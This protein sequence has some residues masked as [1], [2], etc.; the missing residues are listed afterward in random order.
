MS[1][2]L[3]SGLI[4][5][6]TTLKIEQF[7]LEYNPVNYPF[8]GI[9]TTVSGVGFNLAKALT[10]LGNRVNFL[11]IIGDDFAGDLVVNTAQQNRIGTEFILKGLKTTAQSVIIFDQNGKRQIHTDLK[12]IQEQTYPLENFI[13][14]AQP[15]EG[16]AMCNINFSRALLEKAVSMN[17]LV[18]TDV[19][20]LSNL[21]DT[22]NKDFM[23]AANVIFMSDESLPMPPE[24]WATAI[25]DRYHPEVLVI[26]LGSKGALLCVPAES[27]LDFYPAVQTRPI[28]NTIGAG[29]ALFSSFLHSY[30]KSGNPYQSL[31]KAILFASYKIGVKS[32]ADGFL[33][34]QEL[35]ELHQQMSGK[36]NA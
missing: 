29:D 12:D 36:S 25:C 10:V 5:I 26:G 35:Q 7:P 20:T 1:H 17:K 28:V 15:C 27:T 11:S 24:E 21:D 19:H 13:Q 6:E 9:N 14:A 33:S 32:A 8:F 3:V 34:D 18:A 23:N 31:E 30:L 22:Y 4:N 2:I 16:L